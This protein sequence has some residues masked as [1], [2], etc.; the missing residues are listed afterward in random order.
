RKRD[1]E[2]D[3]EKDEMKRQLSSDAW[4]GV[5][6]CLIIGVL[7]APLFLT[8]H[9]GG[10][11]TM[12]IT[13]LYLN[14]IHLAHEWSIPYFTPAVCGGFT[15]AAD[16]Q[17]PLFTL[18][19]PISLMLSDQDLALRISAWFYTVILGLGFFRW[20]RWFGVKES[21]PRAMASVILALNGWW[22]S[23]L[24]QGH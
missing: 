19:Q 21:G 11:A 20:L 17:N 7:S 5:L 4:V 16:A 9:L 18:A 13:H 1:G 23:H 12:F 24:K 3:G 10:D 14:K 8:S 6:L 15:L 2:R 22:V